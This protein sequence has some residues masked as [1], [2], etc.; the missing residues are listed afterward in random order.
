MSAASLTS[1]DEI[2][3][4][5]LAR[6]RP[7]PGGWIATGLT[8]VLVAVAAGASAL[9]LLL[10]GGSPSASAAAI[11]TGS[12]ADATGW[13]TTLLN[14]APLLLVA[15]GACICA[16]AGTFNIGQEGQVL[17]G[18][19]AG[20]WVGLRLALPGPMLVVMVLIAAAVGGG[21]WAALSAL[22]LRLRG[23]NVPVSTLLMTFLA[24]QLVTFAVSTPWL[25]ESAQGSSGIA[26]AASNP[27]P[28]NARLAGFG[29]YP[30]VQLNVGLFIALVAAVGVALVLSRSRWGFRVRM[31][32]LN[33]LTAKHTGVRV[34]ALGGFTLALSG[35]FAGLAGGLLLVSPVGT[36]RLQAGL[37]DNFGWDGLL[38]ALVARNRPLVA[39]PVSLVFAVLRAGGDF[40]SATG[41]PYY[42]VDVVKALLVLAFVAPPVLI[43]L[44]SRRRGATPQAAPDMS[45][46]P[47][48]VKAA[49]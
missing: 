25:Q 48:K 16:S 10:T 43:D 1:G 28:A 8:V 7:G 49:A 46:V 45:V 31:L 37:S 21:A 12:L 24:I 4:R 20:A 17:I 26:D 5:F 11:W 34:A 35:A 36:N 39:I 2:A 47:T 33:P 6:L 40:L 14:A 27:L 9:L 38:V 30:S 32:G 44:F 42:L 22:M 29:Q 18:G 19:L 41:V 23:V 15:V 13:T 3:R